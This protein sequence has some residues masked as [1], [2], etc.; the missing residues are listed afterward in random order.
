[1]IDTDTQLY[2]DDC[3]LEMGSKNVLCHL[4]LVSYGFIIIYEGMKVIQMP[5]HRVRKVQVS[6]CDSGG[7]FVKL[8]IA[9]KKRSVMV[10]N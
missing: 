7:Q 10:F 8:Q 2:I 6:K 4:A 9:L 3:Y 1:M 5:Y